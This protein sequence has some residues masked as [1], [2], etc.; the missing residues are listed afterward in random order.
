MMSSMDFILELIQ[1]F[2]NMKVETDNCIPNVVDC[3]IINHHS[4]PI[5]FSKFHDFSLDFI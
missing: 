4:I 1:H 5:G 3:I 2:S